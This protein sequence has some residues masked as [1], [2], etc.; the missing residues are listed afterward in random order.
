M[1]QVIPKPTPQRTSDTQAPKFEQKNGVWNQIESL[2]KIEEV[3]VFVIEIQQGIFVFVFKYFHVVFDPSLAY[4]EGY[5]VD[6]PFIWD[7]AIHDGL[8]KKTGDEL[9]YGR[10][11]YQHK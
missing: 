4:L 8:L 3:F 1:G 7:T 2:T 5:L 6:F 11:S 10:T 9:Y